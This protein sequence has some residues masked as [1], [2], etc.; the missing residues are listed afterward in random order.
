MVCVVVESP[1]PPVLFYC[2][3][4]KGIETHESSRQ[5]GHLALHAR[6]L[7]AHRWGISPDGTSLGSHLTRRECLEGIVL[8][9]SLRQTLAAQWVSGSK[10]G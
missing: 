8:P 2:R 5:R 4:R 10:G 1:L 7:L 6:S 3:W 9:P